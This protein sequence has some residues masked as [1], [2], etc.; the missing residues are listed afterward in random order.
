MKVMQE[1]VA[2]FERRQ[3]LTPKQIR[4]LLD[5][6]FLAADAPANMLDLLEP[7]GSTFYFRVKGDDQ[8]PL[9]G[10]D[11]YT[12]DSSLAVAAVHAGA[13]RLGET[14]VVKVT[15]VTPLQNYAGAT[16]NGVTSHEFGRYGSAYR[17]ERV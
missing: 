16:R 12:G 11:V 14:G 3:R 10:V 2:Y 5:Q 17:V 6:G 9:W 7:P 1:M 8:G 15:L 4:K 13:V